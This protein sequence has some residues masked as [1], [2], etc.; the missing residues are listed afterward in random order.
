MWARRCQNESYILVVVE[1][2]TMSERQNRIPC[3]F[4]D[5]RMRDCGAEQQ[6]ISNRKYRQGPGYCAGGVRYMERSP[7]FISSMLLGAAGGSV[8]PDW[9]LT[10]SWCVVPCESFRLNLNPGVAGGEMK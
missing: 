8:Q 4:A 9:L 5:N 7:S 3:R 10:S 2:E 6:R 1:F